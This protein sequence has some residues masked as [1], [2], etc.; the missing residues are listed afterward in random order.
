MC[1]STLSSGT[2]LRG[3]CFWVTTQ[4]DFSFFC[5]CCCCCWLC[6]TALLLTASQWKYNKMKAASGIE[7]VITMGKWD[8]GTQMTGVSMESCGEEKKKPRSLSRMAKLL[9]CDKIWRDCSDEWRGTHTGIASTFRRPQSSFVHVIRLLNYLFVNLVSLQISPGER[10]TL[11]TGA[12]RDSNL[13]LSCAQCSSAIVLKAIRNAMG[14]KKISPNLWL[15]VR[16]SR[17]KLSSW[18]TEGEINLHI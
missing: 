14:K 9:L 4:F 18:S 2:P 12:S 1:V 16:F 3:H 13:R 6:A 8:V 11:S 15:N 5:C 7:A 10:I 17:G